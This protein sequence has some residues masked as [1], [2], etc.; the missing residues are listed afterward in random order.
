MSTPNYYPY[1]SAEEFGTYEYEDEDIFEGLIF[2]FVWIII[3]IAVVVACKR[4]RRIRQLNRL[5]RAAAQAN[6]A[7]AVNSVE[8]I[9]AQIRYHQLE[10]DRLRAVLLDQQANQRRMV[11]PV[12]AHRDLN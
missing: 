7:G 5:N 12:I 6:P 8:S 1:N 4:R 11:P 2:V 9:N 10:S 3:V